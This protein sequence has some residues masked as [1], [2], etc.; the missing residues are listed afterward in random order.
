MACYSPLTAQ[1]LSQAQ[2]ETIAPLLKSL[3][4]PVQL[5]LMCCAAGGSA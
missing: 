1:P 3:A 4:D 5:R 2:A